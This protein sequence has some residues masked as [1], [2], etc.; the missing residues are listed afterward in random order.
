VASI[1]QEIAYHLEGDLGGRGFS[2]QLDV[3]DSVGVGWWRLNNIPPTGLV[4]MMAR[5]SSMSRSS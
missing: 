1:A 3:A 4:V 5:R 2:G